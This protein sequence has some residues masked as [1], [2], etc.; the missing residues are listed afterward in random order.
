MNKKWTALSITALAM[1]LTVF[2]ANAALFTESY[3]ASWSY[4]GLSVSDTTVRDDDP[5]THP[6]ADWE[7][8]GT[9]GRDNQL[10]FSRFDFRLGNLTAVDISFESSWSFLST[11][12]AIDSTLLGDINGDGSV[13]GSG[14]SIHRMSFNLIDPNANPVND[15][16]AASEVI[17][18]NC[19]PAPICADFDSASG[20]FDGS[21]DLT[22]IP[23]LDAW[24]YDGMT[25]DDVLVNT[26]IISRADLLGCSDGDSCEQ[27]IG[28]G[29]W[30]GNATL[31]YTYE[32]RIGGAGGG[33]VPEPGILALFAAGL[34]GLGFA[35]R[36]KT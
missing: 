7:Q 32:D 35:G 6:S 4:A 15:T 17:R 19:S 1:G 28:A 36:R 3:T 9:R 13:T 11:L 29:L 20:N 34:V 30:T 26:R 5:T 27:F 10:S 22:T 16:V 18:H 24:L 23:S 31:T 2:Q 8:V 12:Q 14:R 21:V 33:N 25:A